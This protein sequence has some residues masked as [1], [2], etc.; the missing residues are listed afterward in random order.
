[1]SRIR[2]FRAG[3]R[4]TWSCAAALIAAL[5]AAP[6]VAAADDV[7]GQAEAHIVRG[8][9]LREQRED[10]AALAEFEL[11]HKLHPTPRSLVQI[12]LAKQ[13]LGRWVEAESTLEE[14]LASRGDPYVGRWTSILQGALA[15]IRSHLGELAVEGPAGAELVVDGRTAGTLPLKAPV[16]VVAGTVAVE[17]KLAGHL[18]GLRAVVV[19]SQ[20]LARETIVLAPLIPATPER[21]VLLGAHGGS[22]EPGHT[23]GWP[24]P[25]GLVLVGGAAL[26]LGAGLTFHVLRENSVANFNHHSD[27]D[28]KLPDRG[29]SS[30]CQGL[31]DRIVR[32]TTAAVV[33]YAAAGVLGAAAAYLLLAPG[34]GD[35]GRLALCGAGPGTAGVACSFPF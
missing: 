32:N 20:Q 31:H 1:M 4:R 3:R 2:S 8:R 11:A 12:G 27:C 17:L 25:A 23:S 10:A 16:R 9:Q 15:D 6:V 26:A 7:A 19:P 34:D 28:E 13:A 33:G 22:P 24:R 29:D 21:P 30:A 14:A 5:V 35:P 18:S